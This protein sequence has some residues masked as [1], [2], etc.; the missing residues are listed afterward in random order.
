MS[1]FVF[2]PPL[3]SDRLHLIADLK[4]SGYK[5]VAMVASYGPGGVGSVR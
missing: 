1:G 4:S 2:F 5:N 3:T